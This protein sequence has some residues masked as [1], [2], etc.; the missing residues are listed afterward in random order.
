MKTH[1]RH[2][3]LNIIIMTFVL[4]V[5]KTIS[6]CLTAILIIL[7]NSLTCTCTVNPGVWVYSACAYH[8]YVA[9]ICLCGKSPF[10]NIT[11]L[12]TASGVINWSITVK[13][14]L[15]FTNL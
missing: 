13:P 9:D 6:Q 7:Q 2:A 4:I 1:D 3:R 10:Y 8:K 15:K 12:N 11:H 5:Y 14:K